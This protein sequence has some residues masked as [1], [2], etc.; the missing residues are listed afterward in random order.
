[1]K[2]YRQFHLLL[3]ICFFA[4]TGQ[5]AQAE[6][7]SK[8]SCP[9]LLDHTF[10]LL[11]SSK[12]QNL[13]EAHQGKVILVVNTASRCGY[14]PQLEG[15]EKLYKTY[16]NKGFVVL[17]FPSNDFRQE[18][19]NEEDIA[20]FCRK[21]FGVSFPMFSRSS[22]KGDSANSFYQDL[23]KISQ[24]PPAWNFYKYLLN[25]EGELA[26]SFNSRTTPDD[27][28]VKIEALL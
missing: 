27:L 15:L 9:A 8:S 5:A 10:K 12:Q 2:L 23:N 1:M 11:H 17:G 16:Q 6:A 26:N 21:N 19:S 28:T 22:V 14:T 18:L 25:R 20:S 4:L 24:T 7:S 3:T 13:C